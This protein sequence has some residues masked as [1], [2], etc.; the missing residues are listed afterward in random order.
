[1]DTTATEEARSLTHIGDI[2]AVPD[3]INVVL[4]G[5]QEGDGGVAH[6]ET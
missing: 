5:T 3:Q 6:V 2:A 1:M 4:N